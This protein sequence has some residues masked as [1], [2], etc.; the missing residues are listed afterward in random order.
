MCV[1]LY[2]PL[3]LYTV[4]HSLAHSQLSSLSRSRTHLRHLPSGI[5]SSLGAIGAGSGA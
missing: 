1:Y 2:R 5:G 3:L 4:A